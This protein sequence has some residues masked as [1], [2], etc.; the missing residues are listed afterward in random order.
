M[1][2]LIEDRKLTTARV[3]RAVHGGVRVAKRFMSVRDAIVDIGDA[4]TCADIDQTASEGK[5]LRDPLDN[6][7]CDGQRILW[8]FQEFK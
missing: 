2:C 7:M 1:H 3:F 4:N 6:S 5:R 8:V